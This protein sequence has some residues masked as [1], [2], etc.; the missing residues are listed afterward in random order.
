MWHP[1]ISARRSW[2]DVGYLSAILA[3]V[4]L[5]LYLLGTVLLP[6][7]AAWFAAYV[8]IPIVEFLER[9]GLSR[10]AAVACL[11][12]VFFVLISGM[13]IY[14][15][16]T[17]DRQIR[18]LHVELPRYSNEMHQG[19]TLLQDKVER[20]FPVLAQLNLAQRIEQASVV[21]FTE[22]K[23]QPPLN[24]FLL[25][26][27]FLFVPFFT[28]YLLLEGAAMKKSLISWIPNTYFE[29]TLNLIYRIDRQLSQ[30]LFGQLINVVCISLLS[31]IGYSLIG[32]PFGMAI[33]ILS[34]IANL[35]PYVGPLI[36]ASTALLVSLLNESSVDAVI[37]IVLV[38]SAIY[39]FDHLV[40]KP[41]VISKTTDLHPLT[42][43]SIL[44]IG[45]H[46]FGL[47]GLLF[48]IPVFCIA[49]IFIQ[50]FAG[51]L[52]RRRSHDLTPAVMPSINSG[53][54]PPL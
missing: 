38:T 13:I 53:I 26:S 46:L 21:S 35:I 47:W 51:I 1:T 6:F 52:Q 29:A 12:G 54:L 4:G 34:G 20:E 7:V 22:M 19:L 37:Y 45:G 30:Y 10:R 3:I 18:T 11:F 44:V 17:L 49:K 39:A 16:P 5:L 14:L 25:A 2:K 24:S 41:I 43:V 33:G 15:I 9:R 28:W 40:V 8:L 27:S 42:I 50:E 36:G 23:E 48:G 31:A 32:V